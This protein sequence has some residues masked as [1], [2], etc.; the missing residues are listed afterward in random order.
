MKNGRPCSRLPDKDKGDDLV[1]SKP[2]RQQML[3]AH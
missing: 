1:S 2:T 3:A